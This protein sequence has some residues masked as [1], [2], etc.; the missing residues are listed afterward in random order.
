[1]KAEKK[2]SIKLKLNSEEHRML[3]D[4]ITKVINGE[5]PLHEIGILNKQQ[6]EFLK[7]LQKIL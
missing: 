6:L 2:T 1:M 4:I 7:N 3:M 5:N